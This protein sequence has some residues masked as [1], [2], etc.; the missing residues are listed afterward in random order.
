LGKKKQNYQIQGAEAERLGGRGRQTLWG[1]VDRRKETLLEV[2]EPQPAYTVFR[3]AGIR[4]VFLG[5]HRREIA[6]DHRSFR[7]EQDAA[8][9]HCGQPKAQVVAADRM[10]KQSKEAGP[11]NNSAR[12]ED[13]AQDIVHVVESVPVAASDPAVASFPAVA[14]GPG[15]ASV[16]A[17]VPAIASV[18]AVASFP[19]AAS[20]PVDAGA[21]AAVEVHMSPP[22][23][24]SV[25]PG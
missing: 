7:E 13:I 14:S 12:K 20:D 21:V 6:A 5:S 1:T 15:V 8:T 17:S 24:D 11:G 18:P 23:G 19:V 16:A 2:T 9:E 10:G 4:R 22:P 3:R 25:G